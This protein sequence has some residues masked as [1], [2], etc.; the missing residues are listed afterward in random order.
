[1][2][3]GIWSDEMSPERRD[4][5]RRDRVGP[6]G[7]A[8]RLPEV[9]NW[10]PFG[11][12]AIPRAEARIHWE[13]ESLDRLPHLLG[14][15]LLHS[16]ATGVT[17]APAK[18]P[19][20]QKEVEGVSGRLQEDHEHGPPG[21][22]SVGGGEGWL[23][24]VYRAPVEPSTARVR[25]WRKVRELGGLYIQQAVSVFPAGPE[26]ERAVVRLSEEIREM[27]AESFLFLA[28]ASPSETAEI[29]ERF[30][31]QIDQEYR[32]LLEQCRGLLEELA[33]E[34]RRGEF[35]FAEIEENEGDLA[36]IERWAEKARARDF[37]TGALHD[38]VVRNVEECRARM[39]EFEAE[40]FRRHSHEH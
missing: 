1:M 40:V 12:E 34:T 31:A 11:R 5:L 23:V 17:I 8:R 32:E 7:C 27:G 21:H 15:H 22:G 33:T 25:V 9:R 4:P 30:R 19:E 6:W 28:T 16:T 36:Y 24:L 29:I 14:Y 3:R 18:H 13:G 2:A 20:H 38:E 37:F 35:T 26:V 10:R 39:E